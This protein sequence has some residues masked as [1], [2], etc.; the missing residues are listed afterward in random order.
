VILEF[1]L[2]T[3]ASAILIQLIIMAIFLYSYYTL[4]NKPNKVKIILLSTVSLVLLFF[5]QSIKKDYRKAY[6][7]EVNRTK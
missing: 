5:I 7:N 1:V 4:V 2:Y 6:G 3:L